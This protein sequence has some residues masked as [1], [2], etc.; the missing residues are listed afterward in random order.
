[1]AGGY[2]RITAELRHRG[3][4]VNA[5]KVRRLMRENAPNPLRRGRFVKSTD[6]NHDGPVFPNLAKTL[7]VGGPDQL[8]VADITYVAITSGFA[9]V[10][11]IL[12]AFSHKVVD[13]GLSRRI[14]AGLHRNLLAQVVATTG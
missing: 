1:M 9:Y 6:S 8:W 10:A 3:L 5:K 12:E 14:D 2:R 13:N 7:E 4:P 11:V